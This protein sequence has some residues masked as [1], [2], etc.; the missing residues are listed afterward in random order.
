MKFTT[1]A[2]QLAGTRH[3]V[4]WCHP[5]MLLGFR[6]FRPCM[7]DAESIV[8]SRRHKSLEVDSELAKAEVDVAEDDEELGKRLTNYCEACN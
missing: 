5:A 1:E 4:C 2:K 3:T 6:T 7:T 8:S